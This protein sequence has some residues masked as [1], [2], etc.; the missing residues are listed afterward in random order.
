MSGAKALEQRAQRFRVVRLV[1][2]P[3]ER[4]NNL[5][6]GAGE[7]KDNLVEVRLDQLCSQANKPARLKRLNILILTEIFELVRPVGNHRKNNVPKVAS[8]TIEQHLPRLFDGGTPIAS[9]HFLDALCTDLAGVDKGI[10]V[11]L[12]VIREP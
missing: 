10:D 7:V 9:D 3:V 4:A 1:A 12:Q 8:T 2:R 6:I 11:A 5:L